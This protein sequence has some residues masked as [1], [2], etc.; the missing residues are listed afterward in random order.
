[1]QIDM[2]D[3]VAAIDVGTT[4][5]CTLVGRRSDEQGMEVLGYSTVK[6]TGMKKGVVFDVDAT[7][8]AI[9]DSVNAIEKNIGYKVKS[10][11]VGVTGSHI[12]FENRRENIQTGNL[13]GVVTGEDTTRAAIEVSY[14]FEAP[15]RQMIHANAIGF[16]LDGEEGI[17]NPV[18]MHTTQLEVEAHLVSGDADQIGRL[19]KA[20]ESAGVKV[21]ALVLQP[22]ASGFSVLTTEERENGAVIIDIGG[23]TSDIVG[24]RSGNVAYT[25]VIPIGGYQFTND[26][27]TTFNTTFETAESLKIEHASADYQAGALHDEISVPVIGRDSLLKIHRLEICQLVRERALE[28]GRMIRIKL[29]SEQFGDLESDTTSDMTIVLTGGASNLPGFT[30]LVRRTVGVNVRHGVPQLG[31]MVPE[32]LK[33]PIYST[34][35]GILLSGV[36]EWVSDSEFKEIIPDANVDTQLMESDGVMQRLLGRIGNLVPK[37]ISV[38]RKG[39]V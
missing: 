34:V 39:R 37:P 18:G 36:N 14:K 2:K 27:A 9:R 15:G 24:F 35:I 22:I 30:D 4:K 5:V 33:E 1:M 11:F 19:K 3:I 16:A 31:E 38:A 17:R 21:E 28:L 23:G 8:S 25:G 6:N 10:A 29:E 26:I 12:Q 20:V 13:K 7:T 32:D